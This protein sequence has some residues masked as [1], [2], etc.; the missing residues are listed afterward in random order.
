MI[1]KNIL[2]KL[3]IIILLITFNACNSDL[4]NKP[5]DEN[6]GSSTLL[7]ISGLAALGPID[8]GIV[9]AYALNTDG[10]RGSLLGETR[11]DKEGKYNLSCKHS[12]GP[13]E[14]I[15]F[16]GAYVDEATNMPKLM[17]DEEISSI[18][19]SSDDL[20]HY[21]AKGLGISALSSIEAKTAINLLKSA[22]PSAD[23]SLLKQKI[24]QA[25]SFITASYGIDPK[26]AP[27]NIND[28]D[29]L[30]VE[31]DDGKMAMILA[32][33]SVMVNR[34]GISHEELTDMSA[35]DNLD[36]KI[37][38]KFNNSPITFLDGNNKAYSMAS[39]DNKPLNQIKL[40][41][42]AYK[43][44][45]HAAQAAKDHYFAWSMKEA[46]VLADQ[47]VAL[48][49]IDFSTTEADEL[50]SDFKTQHSD[51]AVEETFS[52]ESYVEVVKLDDST[53]ITEAGGFD[54]LAVA[55]EEKEKKS[56]TIVD[57]STDNTKTTSPD[58][59]DTL[60]QN[61][62]DASL[63]ISNVIVPPITDGAFF[64]ELIPSIQNNSTAIVQTTVIVDCSIFNEITSEVFI[65]SMQSQHISVSIS[66][67]TTI[68][69][70]PIFHQS[71]MMYDASSMYYYTC[72][73]QSADG[74]Q[75]DV[76]FQSMSG[77]I[78]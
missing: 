27:A 73:I 19:A 29:N 65:S 31:K 58:T 70:D 67:N 57:N 72:Q 75:S 51:L 55:E 33:M 38:G 44:L 2:Y 23:F 45:D 14:V 8:D 37:D 35:M 24:K 62:S 5:S 32:A 71:N 20:A 63:M 47:E 43:D 34:M 48:E 69:L 17:G 26:T 76:S 60:V 56:E 68:T 53:E 77:M 74:L 16:G 12:D 18:L 40:A 3:P 61:A 30:N 64:L 28:A 41:V 6:T 42:N 66:P 11:T 25:H 49:P 39:T 22:P 7:K 50:I 13:L 21:S 4:F 36:G 15:V 9:R 1:R 52:G 78:K 59:T 46:P 54:E 10:S